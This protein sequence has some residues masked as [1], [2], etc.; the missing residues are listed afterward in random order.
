MSVSTVMFSQQN[1]YESDIKW[2]KKQA[3]ISTGIY[4]DVD[5]LKTDSNFIYYYCK[6]KLGDD[7]TAYTKIHNYLVKHNCRTNENEMLEFESNAKVNKYDIVK[8]YCDKNTV[9]IF[10][11][12]DN[13]KDKKIY[14]F[15]ETYDLDKFVLNDDIAKISEFDYNKQKVTSKYINIF[16][17]RNNDKTILNYYYCSYFYNSDNVSLLQ[18]EIFDNTLKLEWAKSSNFNLPKTGFF[19]IKQELTDS[20]GNL[21]LLQ[22]N[23]DKKSKTEQLVLSLYTKDGNNQSI[24]LN[25]DETKHIAA[26]Q[27]IINDNDD[28]YCTGLYSKAGNTSAIG[29]F[30]FIIDKSL[31]SL[32]NKSFHEFSEEFI[33]RGIEDASRLRDVKK[34]FKKGSDF[35]FDFEYLHPNCHLNK[36]GSY[37]VVFE[38]YVRIVETTFRTNG[39]SDR[40][41]EYD[42]GDLLVIHCNTN[43]KIEWVQKVANY[44][45]LYSL[46]YLVGGYS[47]FYDKNENLNFILNKID[48][49]KLLSTKID[50]SKTVLVSID[51][52]GLEKSTDFITSANTA[53][54]LLANKSKLINDKLFLIQYNFLTD[55]RILSLKGNTLTIGSIQLK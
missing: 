36:S 27:L 47:M 40:D 10:K 31:K 4:D 11:S 21:Y 39:P 30:S 34:A 41:S 43:G 18:Y 14:V 52:N 23:T 1:N 55:T 51:Q 8:Y 54:Q 26:Q 32:G 48:E 3:Y 19:R 42:Y 38:K 53:R 16:I 29:A 13:K 37:D 44:Q 12:F 49:K 46:G 25:L 17:H 6:T 9:H 5:I 24:E 7:F 33:L 22:E 15:H 45:S 20:K 50:K 35:D 28:I 2:G